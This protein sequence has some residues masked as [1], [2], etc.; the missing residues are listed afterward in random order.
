MPDTPMFQKVL[1]IEDDP[2]HA[3]LI[4]RALRLA[5]AEV[6]E[7]AKAATAYEALAQGAFDLI[8][9]DLHLPDSQGVSH[10]GKL[11]ELGPR[12]P[13][14]VLT[15]STSLEEAVEAMKL[16]AS[17]FIVKNFD[18][19][20]AHIFELALARVHARQR[21]ERER[22]KLRREMAAL[23]MAIENSNDGLA[24]LNAMGEV[25]YANTAFNEFIE[26]CGGSSQ[27]LGGF[28]SARV[29]KNAEL[30]AAID[31]KRR[32]LPVG[33]VWHSEVTFVEDTQTAY[34][35]SL[36]VIQRVANEE[37]R[38][39]GNESVVWVRNITEQKR[40]EQ[41]QREI[42]STTT[43]DLKGPLGAIMLSADLAGSLIRENTKA[44]ELI[45]RIASS[46]QNA[47]TLIDEFLSARRIEEGSFILRP[48]LQPLA[49]I[50]REALA[51][52]EPVAA[53]RHVELAAVV[54]EPLAAKVDKLGIV[55]VVGNLLSNAIK[56]TA[57]GG[58]VEVRAFKSDDEVHIRVSDSGS[59]MEP[60]EVAKIF[61][62]FSRLER[63]KE[64]AGT[65]L[66]LFVVRSIVSAH[67]GKIE[68]TS[69]LG[70]GTT[71]DLCLP[72][73]PPVNAAGEL[74]CLDFA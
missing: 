10:V 31:E 64:V 63:H 41:F 26:R 27:T 13:V 70:Q 74:I 21:F 28:F 7:A 9:A 39:E 67:G 57:R 52:F 46:A 54:E 37:G 45:L 65:G 3:L 42:L 8:V 29:A 30:Q 38:E 62:R 73:E 17:D 60:G 1:L 4:R 72:P 32:N 33:S 68:V 51:P 16:G 22:E 35:L 58:K 56:F 14:I 20:F 36:S 53:A 48:A 11:R 61:E 12:T 47:L 44:S 66:G 23:R 34:G 6:V 59:G 49:P 55:R 25:A 18:A 71:F 43:H 69:K 2:S 50:I 15:S 40:R 19:N 24:V 5:S